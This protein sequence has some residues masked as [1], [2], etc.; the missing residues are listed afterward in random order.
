MTIEDVERLIS[1]YGVAQYCHGR[2]SELSNPKEVVGF[3]CEEFEETVEE[4]LTDLLLAI[5]EL[6][7]AH[8][9]D[10]RSDEALGEK[11]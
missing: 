2:A 9:Q 8:Y 5:S 3:T 10:G 1:I 7:L 4:A 11:E 6:N